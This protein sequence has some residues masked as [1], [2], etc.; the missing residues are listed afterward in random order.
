MKMIFITICVTILLNYICVNAQ[1]KQR[2][3][4]ISFLSE[5]YSEYSHLK[6]RVEYIPA[7][8]SLQKIYCSKS[9][10][11]RI[12]ELFNQI[13]LDYDLLTDG[14][15]INPKC[16]SSLK[17]AEAPYSEHIYTVSYV[18]DFYPISTK[19]MVPYLI[20]LKVT[21]VE[22]DNTYRIDNVEGDG[23]PL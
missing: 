4:K 21:L 19:E 20:N 1:N 18:T 14:W 17:I 12:N 5:F 9:F 6:F 3:E 8:D 13:G 16:L 10:I 23:K 22:E 2:D 15:G 7:M 11:Q